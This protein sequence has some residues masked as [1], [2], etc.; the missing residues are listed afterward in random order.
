MQFARSVAG[1]RLT[2]SNPRAFLV[3]CAPEAFADSEQWTSAAMLIASSART[4]MSVLML[5]ITTTRYFR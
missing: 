3:E 5:W 2:E 4:M 1:T